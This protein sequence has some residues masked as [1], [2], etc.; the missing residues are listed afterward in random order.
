MSSLAGWLAIVV[1]ALFAAYLSGWTAAI[2]TLILF[3]VS[4]TFLG[5]AQNNLKDIPFALALYC[6]G[7]L[8]HKYCVRRNKTSRGLSILLVISIG[9]AIW[10]SRGWH[11]DGVLF[12]SL[13]FIES[14]LSISSRKED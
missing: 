13:L 2:F 7:V 12:V 14:C 1:A 9:S 11:F 4:P 5:H 10:Y 3:A 8:F 6:L